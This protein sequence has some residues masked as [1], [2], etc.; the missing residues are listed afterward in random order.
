M[1][2][3][4]LIEEWR[5][6]RQRIKEQ[7]SELTE[8]EIDGLERTGDGLVGALAERYGLSKATAREQLDRLAAKVR[9]SFA[10]A[11]ARV[12]EAA[13]EVCGAGKERVADVFAAGRRQF[14]RLAVAGQQQAQEAWARVARG[15]RHRPGVSLAAAAAVGALL[16]LALRP[17]RR[18]A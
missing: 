7:W 3:E 16:A 8:E 14:A 15:V 5:A 10:T 9:T 1:N 17:R 11:T 13:E 18:G 4:R 2:F 6:L 12:G